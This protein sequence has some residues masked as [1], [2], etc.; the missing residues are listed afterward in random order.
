MHR[1]NV[2]YQEDIKQIQLKRRKITLYIFLSLLFLSIIFI[3]ISTEYGGF[4]VPFI[5]SISLTGL[6][7]IFYLLLPL[8]T[9]ESS[10]YNI[11]IK[12][13]IYQ[14]GLDKQ[15]MIEYDTYTKEK[16]LINA[17][18]LYPK[19][20]SKINRF[21]MTFN[22][23]DHPEVKALYSEIFTQSNNSRYTYLKGLYIVIQSLNHDI[24]QIRTKGKEKLKDI[25]LE[26][27]K[28]S[29][30]TKTFTD[31]DKDIPKI[32]FDI[33]NDLKDKHK[34]VEIAGIEDEIHIAINPYFNFKREKQITNDVYQKY[35]KEIEDIIHMIKDISE[36][37]VY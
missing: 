11:V 9:P 36:K 30:G 10:L 13:I 7:F 29:D 20:T 17:S 15:M 24:F 27:N 23:D 14:M 18:G 28:L 12:D 1:I 31:Q 4:M 25:K 6:A 26:K 3:A 35:Y 21:I 16:D 19:G 22:T 33:Y 5:I 2:A 32:Y 34:E 37:I 8:F